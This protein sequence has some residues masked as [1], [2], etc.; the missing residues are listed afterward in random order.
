MKSIIYLSFSLLIVVYLFSSFSFPRNIVY[1]IQGTAFIDPEL[2]LPIMQ[3][4]VMALNDKPTEE[5]VLR[6]YNEQTEIRKTSDIGV[7]K[8][9]FSVEVEDETQE[10]ETDMYKNFLQWLKSFKKNENESISFHLLFLDDDYE[11]YY[12]KTFQGI[13]SSENIINVDSIWIGNSGPIH[14]TKVFARE[15]N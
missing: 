4:R 15:K 11:L 14:S 7:F 2:T 8:V 3:V 13:P 10:V 6:F 1:D 12:L 9:P 5:D